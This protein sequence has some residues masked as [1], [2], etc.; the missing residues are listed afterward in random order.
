MQQASLLE[1][2]LR[3]DRAVVLA[4]LFVIAALAW[5]YT[6][7]RAYDMG[8]A[9]PNMQSWGLIGFGPMF[10]MWVVMMVA[11]MVPTAAPMILVFATVNR[12]RREQERPYVSTGVFTLGYVLVWTGFAVAATLGS[13][14]LHTHALLSSM[15]GEST[16]SILGGTLLVAA[17]AFQWS[18]LKY[19]CL[20]HC[21]S[22]LGFL[23]AHWEEG[24]EG[25]LRMG[26]KHGTYCLACCWVLMSLLFVLGV[27]NLI[28]IAV[29]AGFILLEKVAPAGHWV[30]R[31]S[32][33]LLIGWGVFV[34]AG[35]S[36]Q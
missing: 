26:L 10:L 34:F 36:Q 21:R 9:M 16:S 28:W 13:W 5:A 15:M 11:V 7:Y 3:R 12:R 20:T 14:A 22:P 30:S 19:V 35:M 33:L 8:M 1:A 18:P 23:M 2:V 17:G 4:G 31:V 25:A 24:I 27:M 32:G 6:V 29:L